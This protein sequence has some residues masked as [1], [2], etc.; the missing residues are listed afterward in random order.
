MPRVT[1]RAPEGSN[2]KAGCVSD[3]VEK[4]AFPASVCCWPTGISVTSGTLRTVG[5]R[6]GQM[7]FVFSVDARLR[8]KHEVS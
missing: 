1:Y 8:D 7:W 5:D 6:G 2:P 4:S 3:Y